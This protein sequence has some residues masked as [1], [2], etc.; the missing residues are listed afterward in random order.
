M[1]YY[2][3]DVD[4]DAN[5]DDDWYNEYVVCSAKELDRVWGTNDCSIWWHIRRQAYVL[6]DYVQIEVLWVELSGWM[7]DTHFGRVFVEWFIAGGLRSIVGN[8]FVCWMVG[9][10]EVEEVGNF[11]LMYNI[12]VI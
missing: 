2:I 9:R 3:H 10:D 8:W 6:T 12:S 4:D 7:G 11:G 1:P 5:D